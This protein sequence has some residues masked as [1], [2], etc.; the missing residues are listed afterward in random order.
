[1]AV[2]ERW[3]RY[4]KKVVKGDLILIESRAA[5]EAANRDDVDEN[6]E[7]VVHAEGGDAGYTKEEIFDRARS[8]SAEEA[9][10]GQYTI[11]DIVLP[12]PGWDIEYPQNDVGDFYKEYMGSDAGGSLDPSDMRRP[13]KDF[14]LSGSYRKIMAKVSDNC[15]FEVRTYHGV[16][17]QMVETDLE[18]L[19]K[20]RPS[21]NNG[22]RN[23]GEYKSQYN[24]QKSDPFNEALQGRQLNDRRFNQSKGA[25][26]KLDDEQTLKDQYVGSSAHN[27]WVNASETITAS[28]KIARDAANAEKVAAGP[29]ADSPL[30][31]IKDTFIEK[32]VTDEGRRTGVRGTVVH[33]A[34]NQKENVPANT[35]DTEKEAD[36]MIPSSEISASTLG[37]T[38][39]MPGTKTP[40]Q[41]DVKID[42][43]TAPVVPS[44]LKRQA[45]DISG[46]PHAAED[47][48]PNTEQDLD[49][50][51]ARLA[52]VLKFALQTSQ[53]ATVALRE[54]MKQGGVKS[55]Q[56]EY[57][58]AR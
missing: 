13:N 58:S 35:K 36:A 37:Q 5:K 32:S 11:Y 29:A 33:E 4:G 51:P 45:A 15:T 20:S 7:V 6:G 2:S 52:V 39:P 57:T 27:A 9:A 18:I 21:R 48:L 53:Y 34:K 54:L 49:S 24:G 19:N 50:Q 25:S 3:A 43:V 23:N 46:S 26:T 30:P 41:N 38:A 56:T 28:D 22:N 14:S 17:E 55:Y 16:T 42:E 10:S 31:Q 44:S 47:T 12:T 1:L 8:L 40:G